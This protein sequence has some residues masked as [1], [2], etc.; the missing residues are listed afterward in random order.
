MY[1]LG[2]ASVE[3]PQRGD[4]IRYTYHDFMV[5]AIKYNNYYVQ[6][7]LYEDRD[8][9][10]VD[11]TKFVTFDADVFSNFTKAPSCETSDMETAHFDVFFTLILP[12]DSLMAAKQTMAFLSKKQNVSK[13]Y[14]IKGSRRWHAPRIN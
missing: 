10:A 12:C 7:R 3:T 2:R 9:H 1:L 4:C 14:V 5:Y 8:V 13:T 6:Q 11:K